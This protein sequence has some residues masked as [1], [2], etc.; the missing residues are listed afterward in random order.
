[1]SEP[2]DLQ[3]LDALAG[4][5]AAAAHSATGREAR[6]LREAILQHSKTE[7]PVALAD[8]RTRQ[9]K[10][11]ERARRDG[12]LNP[13]ATTVRPSRPSQPGALLRLALAAGIAGLAIVA[14]WMWRPTRTLEVA[15]GPERMFRLEAQDPRQLKQQILHD[16]SA[17]GVMATGYGALDAEGIDA[18]L[19]TP[20]TAPVENVLRKYGISTPTDGTLRVEIRAKQPQ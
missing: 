4:K 1:M 14:M 11:L 13:R 7:T 10:L 18:D 19:P 6:M 16:L 12:L 20:L 15:R 17:A 5:S 3:W 2:D 9:A 8:E